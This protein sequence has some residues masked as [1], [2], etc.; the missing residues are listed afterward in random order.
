MTENNS[1]T[2][3]P[4]CLCGCGQRVAPSSSRKNRYLAKHYQPTNVVGITYRNGRKMVTAKDHPKSHHGYVYEYTLIAEKALGRYLRKGEV[5]HHANGDKND[6]R[7]CN[8]VIMHTE[9]HSRMHCLRHK[10]R[11]RGERVCHAKVTDQI[12]RQMREWK[13][14]RSAGEIARTVGL[15]KGAVVHIL[16]RTTWKHVA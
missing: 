10:N 6:N 11:A 2:P 15:S 3:L 5:V 12:V 4:A 8:L 14:T 16:N 9:A 13:G 1:S 7:N